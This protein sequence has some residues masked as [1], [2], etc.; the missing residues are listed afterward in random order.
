MTTGLVY[1]SD[2]L[3]H[4]TG[5]HPERASRV[6]VIVQALQSDEELWNTLMKI[7]P[8]PASKSDIL[9]CHSEALVERVHTACKQDI[10]Y[11]DADTAISPESFDV[12]LLA[13]GGVLSA[14]DAVFE[15]KANN[16]FAVLRPPGHHATPDRA[17]GFCLF[18][19]AAIGARYAQQKHGAETVLI[20][21]WDVHHGNGTQD[22]FYYDNTVYY[23][24]L[25]QYP[26]YPG[27]GTRFERGLGR[28]EGYTLN[29]PLPG[30]TPARHY[31]QAFEDGLKEISGVFSPDLII[32]SAGFDS[33]RLDPLGQLMLE[34]DDFVYL[35]Q[36]VLELADRHCRGRVISCLEGGYNLKVLGETARRHV[37]ALGAGA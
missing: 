33:H 31:R 10:G 18:N 19:N 29:I 15:G 11:L 21:D 17:M 7:S 14:V 16:A 12:A 37:G 3:K 27:T 6:E 25:H 9:L 32:I 28:G 36:R 26:W 1:H 13:A 23:F 22:I 24:S 20:I 2:Y 5:Q 35:T 34:E 8:Q 4:N 30:S